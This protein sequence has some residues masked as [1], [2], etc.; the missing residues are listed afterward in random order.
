MVVM[1]NEGR[2]VQYDQPLRI[3]VEP[4]NDFVSDLIGAGDVLRRLSLLPVQAG[5]LDGEPV[6]EGSPTI[7][8]SESLRAALGL[9]LETNTD[10][11][12][13]VDDR[14]STIGAIDLRAIQAVSSNTAQHVGASNES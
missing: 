2:I 12:R 10:R 11:V 14:G 6:Q 5:M 3:L 1:M 7:S 9:L 4:A 8:A 13:V